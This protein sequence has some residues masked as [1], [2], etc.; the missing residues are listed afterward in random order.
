LAANPVPERPADGGMPMTRRLL[1]LSAVIG[2]AAPLAGCATRPFVRGELERSAATLR[3]V[4]DRLAGDLQ[5]HRAE[6]QELAAAV[7]E[8]VRATEDATRRA[9]EA[10]GVADVAAGQAAETL[11]T[12]TLALARADDAGAVADKALDDTDRVA[13]RLTRLWNRR[14]RSSVVEAIVV[15]F[16]VDEWVL[17]D[18]ARAAALTV[19]DRLRENPALIVELEGYAD[20]AG[21]RPHNLRL[22]Q[23]RA[24]A[25]G[26]FLVEQ[27]VA[28]Y[29][30]QTIG[31]GTIRPVAD[32]RTQ[33]GR[34]Q[35]RRVVVRLLDPS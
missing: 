8:T 7:V 10:L 31:L 25:V 12:V 23:L 14:Q 4:I 18:E 24:E 28:V 15:R 1:L 26:R 20:G 30:L 27:G 33:E 22:S 21:A 34:R 17:D 13:E 35:N 5:A 29:R 6:V 16:G 32:N 2:L 19:A 3:P 9:I 11:D